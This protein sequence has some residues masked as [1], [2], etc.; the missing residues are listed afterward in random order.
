MRF[1]FYL[2]L[3]AGLCESSAFGCFCG[4]DGSYCDWLS[5]TQIVFV[6]RVI[7]D[8]GEGHG[9]G[10]AR[11]AIEEILHG[12]PEDI[13]EVTVDTS[14]GT[15]CYMRLQK[16]EQYVIYATK[17]PG[18]FDHIKR[19][20]CSFSF[21][22]RGNEKLLAA[23]RDAQSA[24]HTT[25]V[26]KVSIQHEKYGVGGEGAAGVPVIAGANGVRLK[27]TT[28]ANGEFEFRAVA[29]GVYR[30][31][32]E[33]KDF[34]LDDWKFPKD[35]PIVREGSC[36]YQQLYVFPNGKI[37][38]VVH[39]ADGSPLPGVP[40]QAFMKDARGELDSS[41]LR[42]QKTDDQG[43]YTLQGLPPG[44]FAIGINGEKYHDKQPWRPVFYP[45]TSS[46]NSAKWVTL[47]RSERLSDINL[48][49]S[50][51]R[52]PATLH[53]EAVF[54][55][56]APATCGGANVEDLSGVQ[57]ALAL[58]KDSPGA[59]PGHLDVPV[60]AGETYRVRCFRHDVEVPKEARLGQPFRMKTTS[61]EGRSGPVQM[62][63]RDVYIRVVLSVE[64]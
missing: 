4:M 58:A 63:Q 55:D 41:P 34:L 17:I 14:A 57:R 35:D 44:D 47:G 8:S 29:P 33:S 48:Q 53:I 23:L 32:T 51:P 15:S 49:V 24:A 27:T 13:R 43:R 31:E 6:G 62:T 25:L 36:G 28:D 10:P 45:G 11:M 60:Y 22:L 46:R 38:G 39:T 40:V 16:D 5:H 56:G 7:E 54:E 2:G 37:E 52:E 3:L 1:I 19:K 9:K 42:E 18:S 50:D 26:G 20:D 21:A 61:W 59:A 12:L 64:K 30:L